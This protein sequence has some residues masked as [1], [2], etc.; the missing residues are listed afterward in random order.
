MF[1]GKDDSYFYHKS[2]SGTLSGTYR[3]DELGEYSIIQ[4][5]GYWALTTLS[6]V[7]FGDFYPDTTYERLTSIVVIFGGYICFSF[8]NG[9]LLNAIAEVQE[10][11]EEYGDHETLERFNKVLI[12]F[13]NDIPLDSEF[14]S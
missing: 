14:T 4:I 7:G 10:I 6:T 1:Y 12:K 3:I 2:R 5:S 9:T 8:V 13:N 11:F